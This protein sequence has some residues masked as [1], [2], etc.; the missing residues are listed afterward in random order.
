MKNGRFLLK[1]AA[2]SAL[3]AVL[4]AGAAVVG[5]KAFFPEPKARAWLIDSARRQLGRD[6]RLERIDVGFRGLLLSGL[7]ISERPDF[8]AGTFLRVEA[9][10]LRPSWKALVRRR[11]VVAAVTAEGLKV[12]VVKGADGHFNYETLAAAA[13]AGA[14]ASRPAAKPGE[15][16]APEFD[17]RRAVVSGGTVEYSD[18]AAGAAWTLDKLSLTATNVGKTEPFGVA[19]S[20]RARGQAGAR[21][22][23]ARVDF[24]GLVGA[25]GPGGVSVNARRLTVEQGG[26]KLAGAAKVAGT[27]AP[28]VD[29]DAALSYEGV[30]TLAASGSA[31][32]GSSTTAVDVKGRTPALPA[33]RLAKLVPGEG[34]PAIDA[35]AAELA[36]TGSFAAGRAEVTSFR[37]S[38]SGG[39]L[40]VSGAARGLDGSNPLYQGRASFGADLPAVAPG[41]YPFLKLPAK[42][43]LPASRLDGE[44]MLTPDGDLKILSLTAKFKQGTLSASGAIRKASSAKPVPGV[45]IAVALDLPAFKLS[46]LFFPVGSLSPSFVVPAGRLTGTVGL[47]GDD[48]RLEKA[49]FRSRGAQVGVD[50]TLGK[51]LAGEFA[52]DLNVTADLNLPALTGE[53]LP[54]PGAHAG[55]RLP[56]SHWT[57]ETGYSAKLM[58]VKSLR[59]QI[60]KNDVEASGTV[61]DPGGRGAYDLL[62]KCRSFALEELTQLTPATRDEKLSGTG[63]F[64]LSMTGAE[65]KPEFAGRAQFRN[66]GATLDGLPLS[67]FTGTVS[68]D[69]RRI[70]IPNLTGKLAE[71]SLRMDLTVKDYGTLAPDVQLEASLD[72]FDLGRYLDAKD[73]LVADRAAAKAAK[74]K[75]TAGEREPKPADAKPPVFSTRGHLD[76]GALVHPNGTAA[77]VKLSWELRGV[78]P[79]LRGLNGDARLHVGGGRLRNAG[80]AS[81]RSALLKVLLFPMIVLQKIGGSLAGFPNFNDLE[82]NRIEGDYGFKNGL[83]TLRQAEIDAKNTEIQAKGTID[84]PSEI[85]DLALTGTVGRIPLDAT[86]AGT[87]DHLKTKINYLKTAGQLLQNLLQKPADSQ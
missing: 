36:L 56:P 80:D 39:K 4:G 28:R 73:K 76:V 83:M 20:F 24:D 38:W 44:L 31:T 60:G 8:A 37:A 63:F 52:P 21:P 9:F 50:G 79:D 55:L 47:A 67:D 78:A 32:F 87:P 81:K 77:D 13:S 17:V 46:E 65:G 14:A 41:E 70:D 10:R 23:D 45:S 59:V 69:P 26:F 7:E 1:A 85:L 72:K 42:L 86:V 43:A 66:L 11:F 35:P 27:A 5:L 22:I 12:R 74:A 3:I 54:F 33:A 16:P 34:L 2:A 68:F 62:F 75:T 57:T 64:A 49:A 61:T 15:A 84:I 29:F 40:D 18:P 82:I 53:D 25:G 58:R 19:A 51:A 30:E 6:V 48:V 71:G